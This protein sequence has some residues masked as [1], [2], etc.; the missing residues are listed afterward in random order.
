MAGLNRVQIIGYLGQ[1]PELRYTQAGVPVTQISVA[2]TRKWKNKQTEKLEEDTEWHRVTCWQRL[3]E[4]VAEFLKKGAMVYVEGRLQ[5]TSYE[6]K[7]GVKR[8]S[9]E[10]VAREVQF[11]DR[12]PGGGKRPPHPSDRDG[13]PPPDFSGDYIPSDPGDDDIPF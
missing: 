3:G 9:T 2:T 1:D 4:R 12:K 5:T 13:G 7:E 6:D 10:I 8:W 11:L